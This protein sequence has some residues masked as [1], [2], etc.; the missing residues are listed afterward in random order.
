MFNISDQLYFQHHRHRCQ[1]TIRQ[2]NLH[3][4]PKHPQPKSLP[5]S[6]VLVHLS[7]LGRGCSNRFRGHHHCCTGF[8]KPTHHLEYGKVRRCRHQVKDVLSNIGN[9]KKATMKSLIRGHSTT[10]WTRRGGGG[11][12]KIP[13]FTMAGLGYFCSKL[14][15]R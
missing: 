11:S 6:L 8:S 15:C 1:H 10:T 9:S 14:I 13:R 4:V 12:A 3:S 2:W 7:P 5:G